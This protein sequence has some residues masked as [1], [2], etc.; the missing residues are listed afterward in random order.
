[1]HPGAV[2]T[3]LIESSR[4]LDVAVR[5]KESGRLHRPDVSQ[6]LRHQG[7]RF[8]FGIFEQEKTAD[9]HFR[10]STFSFTAAAIQHLCRVNQVPKKD[11][12]AL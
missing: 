2:V 11:A 3:N 7:S 12:A 8:R 6:H 10:G 5:E 1:M 9:C 4:Q